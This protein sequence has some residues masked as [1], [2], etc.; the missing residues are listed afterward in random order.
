MG[1]SKFDLCADSVTLDYEE[2]VKTSIFAVKY[3]LDALEDRLRKWH[4]FP[5]KCTS[6]D[7]GWM[8]EAADALAT[9]TRAHN[10]LV[11]G[12]TR[13]KVIIER[14]EHG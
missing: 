12:R 11:E 8:L 13:G 10:Y 7:A 9:A 3:S 5:F 14:G 6:L 1:D 4:G 2:L